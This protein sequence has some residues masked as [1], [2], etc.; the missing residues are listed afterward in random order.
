MPK[1]GEFAWHDL[2]TNDMDGSIA[3]YSE[4]VGWKP[5]PM[6]MGGSSMKYTLFQ[7]G[8]VPV[9]GV[10]A[11]SDEMK[12]MGAPPSWTPCVEVSDLDGTCKRTKDLGGKLLD[13]P[14][15][16]PGGRF[17][18]LQD[19]QGGVFECF[20]SDEPGEANPAPSAGRFSWYDLNTTD[21]ESAKKFYSELFG[22]SES[23]TMESP[24]GTY[25]MFKGAT[26]DRTLGGMS[27]MAKQMKL[28]P[29]WLCYITV[30]NLDETLDRLK[31][32]GGKVMNGPMEVPGGD[33]VAQ[34]MDP[35]GAAI[36]FHAKA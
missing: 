30:D 14:N 15:P 32:N 1:H 25:W 18:V 4:T 6:D 2:A 23:S 22:W 24:G 3:F 21:W 11:L 16:A 28:P 27:D 35:Q 13:G 7:L 8:D 29:H 31:S 12:S 10:M 26:D 17:A 9:G 33:R 19:P 20:G 36:A 5:V 34:C